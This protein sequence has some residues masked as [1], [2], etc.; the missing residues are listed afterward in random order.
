MS[1]GIYKITNQINGKVYIGQSVNIQQRWIEHRSVAFNINNKNYNCHLYCSIRKYG[2]ENFI[3]TILEECSQEELNNKEIYWI[4]YYD[5]T[6]KE[7][8]YNILLGG[9]QGGSVFDYNEIFKKWQEGY[10][11]KELQKMFHCSDR[12]IT[13]ALRANNISESETKSRSSNK[14]KFVALSKGDKP[15]KIFEG[16]KDVSLYFT[17]EEGKADNLTYRIIPNHCSM[18]G[19]YW[20]YLNEGNIPEKELTDEEFLS[21]QMPNLF[22]WSEAEKQE[23]SKRQR[24]VERPSREELKELIR[25]KS[26]L[27]IGRMFNVSDNAIRK[28]CDFE[29]LPRKKTEINK[30]SDEEWELI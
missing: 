30:Y 26:F 4:K 25:T 27:E 10:T 1:M 5:S 13:S 6:N 2:I 8:G 24:I 23:I 20:D 21:Y 3:L 9:N 28:W 16:M 17:K 14:N 18:F 19:Y 15:L 29:K 22:H 12:V 11:C 7:K